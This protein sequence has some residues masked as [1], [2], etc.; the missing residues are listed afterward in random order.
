M[1]VCEICNISYDGRIKKGCPKC[2][3]ENEELRKE[4]RSKEEA[5]EVLNKSLLEVPRGEAAAFTEAMKA[6]TEMAKAMQATVSSM[7][8]MMQDLSL[9]LKLSRENSKSNPGI[10]PD[11]RDYRPPRADLDK[12]GG[13]HGCNCAC[14]GKDGGQGVPDNS[15][16][17]GFLEDLDEESW[18]L[19]D[20]LTKAD[21]KKSKFDIIR[22]LPES[23]RKKSNPIDTSARLIMLLHCLL[24][25][26]DD[27]KPVENTKGL[28]AHIS[29]LTVK[30]S[31]GIYDVRALLAY[32]SA[33]R[34]KA[35]KD[36]IE[37]FTGGDTKLTNYYLGYSGTI[38]AMSYAASAA[39]NRPN[40][41]TSIRKQGGS[42]YGGSRGGRRQS[43]TGWKKL[44]AEK[45]CCFAFAQGNRCDGCMF[46][47]MC[48]VCNATTHGM[49]T[50]AHNNVSGGGNTQM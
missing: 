25:E 12:D 23:D 2:H 42:S 40:S 41:T 35:S 34:E 13:H 39:N 6:T 37:A 47:H 49:S 22:F 14:G 44:C 50:C 10:I 26:L 38:Q 16:R 48:V 46:K 17:R 31:E 18:D 29:Y 15:R 33:M 9:E 4:L 30:A 3:D 1:V 24:D 32:D 7:Q 27:S 43:F 28:R 5:I 8:S 11:P 45:N 19:R 21:K 20:L 36:G